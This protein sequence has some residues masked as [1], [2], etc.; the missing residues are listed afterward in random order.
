MRRITVSL[1][2][3]LVIEAMVLVGT[4]DPQDAVEVVMRDY[5]A[6]GHRTEAITGTAAEERRP[7]QQKPIGEAG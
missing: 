3:D 2:A 6:R 5:V 7:A 1:D 4:S